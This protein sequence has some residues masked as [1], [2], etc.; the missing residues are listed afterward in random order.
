[1]D[2]NLGP[3]GIFDCLPKQD[4]DTGSAVNVNLREDKSELI[5][6]EYFPTNWTQWLQH[7]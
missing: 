1:M 6:T 7:L 5:R 3:I 4:L 2:P